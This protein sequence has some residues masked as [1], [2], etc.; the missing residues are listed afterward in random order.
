MANQATL[1][2]QSQH[3]ARIIKSRRSKYGNDTLVQE[4]RA[5]KR[6]IDRQLARAH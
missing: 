4:W 2:W 5:R 1:Q 3:L 6:R